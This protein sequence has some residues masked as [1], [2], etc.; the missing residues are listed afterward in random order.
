MKIEYLFPEYCNLYGDAFN[1][2]FLRRCLPEATF[3]QTHL[4]ETPRFLSEEMDLVYLGPM[5]ERIQERVIEKLMPE[6]GALHGAIENGMNFL[7]IGNALEI[8]G[9]HIENEDGSRVP[10]LGILDLWAKRNL[11][12]RHNSAF[13]GDMQGKKLMGFKTQ[14]TMCYPG[15]SITGLAT[16]EKGVGLNPD[17]PF[18]GVVAQHFIGTYLTGPLLITNPFF[19]KDLL[20]QLGAASAALPF[21]AQLLAAYEAKLLDFKEKV[22]AAGSPAH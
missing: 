6:K 4:D 22:N 16:V 2:E 11:T 9:S 7:F 17:C 19:T 8:L 18:E 15:P 14:F 10:A 1:I 13:L 12:T 3:I 5:S 21:E 20:S